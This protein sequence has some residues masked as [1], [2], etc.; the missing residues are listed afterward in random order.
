MESRRPSARLAPFVSRIWATDGTPRHAPGT[1][2][3][4]VL[5]NGAAHL[6]IRLESEPLRL[7]DAAGER[8]V[9]ELG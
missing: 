7:L 2:V 3:E 8:V 4:R 5:P 6:V 9:A 1:R